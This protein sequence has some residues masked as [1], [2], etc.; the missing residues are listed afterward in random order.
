MCDWRKKYNK[1]LW[2]STE[3]IRKRDFSAKF[4]FLFFTTW[5][6]FLQH[7]RKLQCAC[8]TSVILSGYQH[9]HQQTTMA[10]TWIML[11]L[12]SN[13]ERRKAQNIQRRPIWW[14]K[15]RRIIAMRIT[16]TSVRC[17][18]H[19]NL[20]PTVSYCHGLRISCCRRLFNW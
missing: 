13:K 7:S 11:L 10:V 17:E 2:K 9:H 4:S 1:H 20:S 3:L 8:F 18:S 6:F 19:R 5:F 14:L 15:F 16:A 12:R